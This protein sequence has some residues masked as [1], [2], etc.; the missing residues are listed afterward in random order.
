M[1]S[2]IAHL[3]TNMNVPYVHWYQ[4]NLIK[5][6]AVGKFTA[7]VAWRSLKIEGSSHALPVVTT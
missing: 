5:L 1:N 2:L 6:I 3:P 7:R 4:G